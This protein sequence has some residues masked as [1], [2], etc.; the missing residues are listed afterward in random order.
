VRASELNVRRLPADADLAGVHALGRDT[1]S[2]DA[3]CTPGAF[4]PSL[5]QLA[6]IRQIGGRIY[7]AAHAGVDVGFIA[8]EPDARVAWLRAAADH[9]GAVCVACAVYSYED[10]GGCW[11]PVGNPAVRRAVVEASDGLFVDEGPGTLRYVP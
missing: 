11:G 3:Q 1:F 2:A 9:I 4:W 7:V 10:F 8:V 6:A 5:A